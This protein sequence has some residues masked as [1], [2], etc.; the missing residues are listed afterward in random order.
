[1]YHWPDGL[2]QRRFFNREVKKISG[3]TLINNLMISK[4]IKKIYIIGNSSAKQINFIKKKFKRKVIHI[5]LPY[6]ESV[7]EIYK[8]DNVPKIY[9]DSDLIF[10]TL[11]TP[12]QEHFAFLLAQN[13]N[14]KIICIGGALSMLV[15]EEKPIP[16]YLENI[17]GA[18][19]L[20]RL[21][22]DT[23][24]RSQRLFSTLFYYMIGEFFNIYKNIKGK[25]ING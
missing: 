23:Y 8:N 9:K 20:W 17:L 13:N 24:R 2:F 22:T 12:K 1:M 3:R 25:V 19:A 11:P 5:K 6:H 4:E 14:Y 18:E 21:K 16:L 10:I 15:G 7:Y